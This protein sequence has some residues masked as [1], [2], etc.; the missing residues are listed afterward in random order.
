MKD[1]DDIVTRLGYRSEQIVLV[2]DTAEK[3]VTTERCALTS[4]YFPCRLAGCGRSGFVKVTTFDPHAG[5][6]DQLLRVKDEVD[7]FFDNADTHKEA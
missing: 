3:S 1:L 6:D 7:K 2:D 4:A 5:L